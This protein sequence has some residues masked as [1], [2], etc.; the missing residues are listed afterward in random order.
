MYSKVIQ[1]YISMSACLRVLAKL[2]QSCPMDHSPPGSSV[3][4]ILQTRILE[5]VAT[6]SFR[7]SSQLRD[8]NHI[9]YVSC[10][11]RWV[12]YHKASLIQLVHALNLDWRFIS[13]MI[14]Y[15]FQCHSPKSSHPCPLP[16]SPKSIFLSKTEAE[17]LASVQIRNLHNI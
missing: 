11:S 8:W 5:W 2:L 3:H 14:I 1:S 12:L 10:I 7:G 17:Y 16:Q 15:M 9:S 6:S 4:A 13:Y